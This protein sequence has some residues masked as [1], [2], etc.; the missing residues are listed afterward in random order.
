V[1]R[2]SRAFRRVRVAKNCYVSR[3]RYLHLAL[4]FALLAL[5]LWKTDARDVAHAIRGVSPLTAVIV[6]ALNV[7]IGLLL[8]VR[9]GMV[10]KRLG[11]SVPANILLP[12]ALLGNVAGSLTPASAG[13]LLRTAMLKNHAE[14]STRDGV[15]LV[16]YERALSTYLMALGTGVVAAFVALPI[17]RAVLVAACSAPLFA[18]PVVGAKL[19][20]ILPRRRIER[21]PAAVRDLLERIGSVADRLQWLLNDRRLLAS[22]A[23]ITGLIFAGVT[24][25]FY[26]LTRALSHAVSPQEAW[27]ALGASQLASVA[28][29]LPL[30]LGAAD[31]SVAAILHRSGMTLEQGTAVAILV[32][33]V[34]T[35]PLGIAAIL[36]YLYLQ[37]R[38]AADGELTTAD[39]LE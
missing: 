27:V 39:A 37:R 3:A 18:L 26:L 15:A 25:Q 33:A 32:R 16:L 23:T 28:S 6:V 36:C 8:G 14:V 38:R 30:G 34:I 4:A 31:G 22:W 5:L 2:A 35:L 12:A 21:G 24:L 13:E 17:T 11:H 19:L 20:S 29:L 10:L 1:Y 7:P 9:S